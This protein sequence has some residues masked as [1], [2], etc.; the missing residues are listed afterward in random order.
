MLT[1][2]AST[3]LTVLNTFYQLILFRRRLHNDSVSECN[4]TTRKTLMMMTT[5]TKANNDKTE[6]QQLTIYWNDDDEA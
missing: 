1:S 4:S 2:N 3:L 5:T 6:I